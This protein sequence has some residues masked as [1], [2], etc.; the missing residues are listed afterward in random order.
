MALIIEDCG[1][2]SKALLDSDIDLL[3]CHELNPVRYPYLLES[4]RYINKHSRFDILFAFPGEQIRA[5]SLSQKNFFN[6]FDE[7]FLDKYNKAI[8]S[9]DMPFTGGWF[10]FL[11]YELAGLIEPT[12]SNITEDLRLPLALATHIPVAIIKDHETKQNWMVCESGQEPLL[13][14]VYDDCLKSNINKLS[15]T[16]SFN[17]PKTQD[18]RFL[19]SVKKIHH[20]IKEGDTFQVNLSKQWEAK[21]TDNTDY[22]NVY[23]ALKSA[24]PSPFAG[25]AKID[26]HSICSTSPER[27]VKT[28]GDEIHMRPIAGTRRRSSD[29]N[30]DK[31]LANDLLSNDKEMAEHIMLIDLVRNDLGRVCNPGSIVVDEKMTL[32]SYATVH[33]IVSNVRGQIKQGAILPSD[34]IKAVFPGGTITGCP[35]VRCMEIINELEDEPRGAYTGS[36]GY[37]NY[38]GNMDLNILIRSVVVN[39]QELVFRTGAGIVADSVASAELKETEHKARGMLNALGGDHD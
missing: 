25:L 9:D 29:K 10:I 3:S 39:E 2:Y 11:S 12:L 14:L 15:K 20:Y 5:E 22:V 1:H 37:I 8:S 32:E 17:V 24:N 18:K 13:K 31:A 19:S 27:L 26:N 30:K 38:N 33:H 16:V 7:Q 36:I 21:L 6:Q 4:H 23:R 35:K 28:E 34:I